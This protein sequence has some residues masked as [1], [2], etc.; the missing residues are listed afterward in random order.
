MAAETAASTE[1]TLHS[2][3]THARPIAGGDEDYDALVERMGTARFVLLGEA[4]HGTHEFYRERDRITRRL[5]QEHGFDGVAV[6]ADW[7][8]ASRANRYVRA[9]GDDRDAAGALEDF[10]RFP[11]WMWR[12]TVTAEFLEWLRSFNA[13]SQRTV[14]F[15][16]LDLYSLHSSFE[17]VISYL[18]GVDPAAARRARERFSCFDHVAGDG[19]DY[20]RQAAFGAGASCEDEVVGQLVELCREAMRYVDEDVADGED[21]FFDVERNA[22]LVVDAERYYRTMLRGQVSSWN[23]RDRHMAETL[24]A[25]ADHLGRRRGRPAKVVVWAHNSHLGDARATDRAEVGEWNVGQLMREGHPGEVV[26]V[27]FTTFAG[28]V[29]RCPSLGRRARRSGGAARAC[30]KLRAAC[31]RQRPR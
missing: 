22:Q 1:A 15:Y 30:G 25:L 19:A 11:T 14:G 3:R 7:P 28:T 18:E 31:P 9:L 24:D 13:R 21:A 23:L 6:E 8:D 12:N 5:I 2:L 26:N 17:A 27:G 16:G 4:S 10:R 20:A 29:T